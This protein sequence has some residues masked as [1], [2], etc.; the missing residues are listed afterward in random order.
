M[1]HFFSEIDEITLTFSDIQTN[2]QGM[3]YIKIYFERP[4]DAGFDFLE[5]TLPALNIKDSAG[6]SARELENLL[7][8]ARNNA[9]LIWEIAREEV[10]FRKCVSCLD[11]AASA[12]ENWELKK[13][14]EHFN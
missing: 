2:Q 6:F 4:S 9:F 5:S 13:R 12:R 11:I 8:Y 7:A 10:F 14:N 1:K 3:E